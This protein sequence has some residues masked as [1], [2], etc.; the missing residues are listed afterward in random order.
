MVSCYYLFDSFYFDTG[1]KQKTRFV[2]EA[3]FLC[4]VIYYIKFS[5]PCS[6]GIIM[7]ITIIMIALMMFILLNLFINI[8]V[9]MNKYTCLI[10]HC[11]ELLHSP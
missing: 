6:A 4:S 8:E 2:A 3:G 9:L 1:K 7:T 11:K 5:L 10:L